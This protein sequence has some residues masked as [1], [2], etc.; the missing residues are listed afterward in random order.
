MTLTVKRNWCWFH[1]STE[2]GMTVVQIGGLVI[3]ME[4]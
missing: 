4:L 2:A 3:E 1:H